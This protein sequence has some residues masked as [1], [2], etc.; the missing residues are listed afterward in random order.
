MGSSQSRNGILE[1]PFHLLRRDGRTQTQA[2]TTLLRTLGSLPAGGLALASARQGP[3]TKSN[4]GRPNL[5]RD[6]AVERYKPKI[7]NKPRR[8]IQC[9][10]PQGHLSLVF[11]SNGFGQRSRTRDVGSLGRNV[12]FI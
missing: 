12:D 9:P 2:S 8:P 6:A 3:C 7:F 4:E 11:R 5:K 1:E 10:H